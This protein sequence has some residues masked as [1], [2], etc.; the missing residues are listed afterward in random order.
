MERISESTFYFSARPHGQR[1]GLFLSGAPRL[2]CFGAPRTCSVEAVHIGV[3][4]DRLFDKRDAGPL[5][6]DVEYA[7]HVG[8]RTRP[9]LPWPETKLRWPRA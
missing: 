6:D 7:A 1:A 8:E 9:G 5:F 3:R 2:R 4:R